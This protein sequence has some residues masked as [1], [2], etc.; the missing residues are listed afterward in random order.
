[1]KKRRS[2]YLRIRFFSM[3]GHYDKVNLVQFHPMAE[4]ILVTAAFDFTI[5]IWDLSSDGEEKI[6]LEG[7]TEEVISEFSRVYI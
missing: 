7:H 6:T 3:S 1:M 2:P 4:N 5:K